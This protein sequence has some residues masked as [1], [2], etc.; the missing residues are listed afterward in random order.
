MP[1]SALDVTEGGEDFGD[2]PVVWLVC[3]GVEAGRRLNCSSLTPAIVRADAHRPAVESQGA[4]GRR[5]KNRHAMPRRRKF[6]LSRA[7]N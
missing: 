6:S 5:V 4:A 7:G 3:R 2:R 1:H